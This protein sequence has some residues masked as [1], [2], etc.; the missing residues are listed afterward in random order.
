MI[1]PFLRVSGMAIYPFILV[2]NEAAR[3]DQVL[4]N[5]EKIHLRQQAELMVVPFYILYL[6][7][8]LVNIFIYRRHSKAY[9]NICFEREAYE[10][11]KDQAYLQSR[12]WYQ[13]IKYL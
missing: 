11:E 13:W 12:K 9:R 6:L 4:I 8:Y 1:V 3:Y 7:N 10:Y 2:D 5:H